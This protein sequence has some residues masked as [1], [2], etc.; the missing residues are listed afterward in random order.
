MSFLLAKKQPPKQNG[1]EPPKKATTKVSQDMFIVS[2]TNRFYTYW[3]SLH[4]LC[5]LASSYVYACMAAFK[6]DVVRAVGA[7]HSVRVK[8]LEACFGMNCSSP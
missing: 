6:V 2:S 7:A 1:G 3:L 4:T 8:M 5:C